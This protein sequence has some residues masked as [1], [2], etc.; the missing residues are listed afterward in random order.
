MKQRGGTAVVSTDVD[1]RDV[2]E[3]EETAAEPGAV[4]DEGRPDPPAPARR[5]PR[6]VAAV[7]AVVL[8]VVEAGC[9]SPRA[10]RCATPPPPPTAH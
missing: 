9:S 5:W 7:L 1:A 10:E 6:V 3:H 4:T 2:G 8:V